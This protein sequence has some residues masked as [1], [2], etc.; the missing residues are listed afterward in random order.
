[1][2]THKYIPSIMQILQFF[3]QLV[4]SLFDTPISQWHL[5]EKLS[6]TTDSSPGVAACH[7]LI[8]HQLYV[9]ALTY[10]I[11]LIFIFSLGQPMLIINW[12]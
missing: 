1:M 9:P 8:L 10:A 5:L 3:L 12:G 7:C 6:G 4:S 11:L 2:D